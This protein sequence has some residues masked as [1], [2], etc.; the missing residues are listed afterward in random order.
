MPEQGSM[1]SQKSVDANSAYFWRRNEGMLATGRFFDPDELLFTLRF[2]DHRLLNHTGTPGNY[3]VG[4]RGERIPNLPASATPASRGMLTLVP[5]LWPGIP[6]AISA[7][8]RTN[9]CTNPSFGRYTT[10]WNT[11]WAD[12][13]TR[14]LERSYAG[15]YS[16]KITDDAVSNG[17]G[18]WNL[19]TVTIG[20]P[21]SVGCMINVPSGLTYTDVT[22]RV[23]DVAFAGLL[24]TS[25]N[26]TERDQWVYVEVPNVVPTTVNLYVLIFATGG[27]GPFVGESVY[28][29]CVTVVQDTYSHYPPFDGNSGDGYTWTGS[30]E[31]T[32]SSRVYNEIELD[33]M[34][35]LVSGN[36][37]VSYSIWMQAMYDYDTSTPGA[38][39]V[40]LQLIGAGATQQ[41][42]LYDTG[43]NSFYFY[44][45]GTNMTGGTA[46]PFHRGD[47]LHFVATLDYTNDEY[48]IWIN[49]QLVHT[50]T[51]ALTAPTLTTGILG[52]SAGVGAWAY[53][54]FAAFGR[55]LNESEVKA[56]HAHR[57]PLIDKYAID[58]KLN[59]GGIFF[60]AGNWPV[61]TATWTTIPMTS[62]F[63][64]EHM[65]LDRTNN[66]PII[67]EP[68][69]YTLQGS[70]RWATDPVGIRYCGIYVNGVS[71]AL[72]NMDA[73]ATFDVYHTATTTMYLVPG[74]YVELRG[75][76]T[77][78]GNLNAVYQAHVGNF[79]RIVKIRNVFE[80]SY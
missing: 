24:G 13:L 64:N 53:A 18:A 65:V 47:W 45:N 68:G 37:T 34:V 20:L 78:G 31:S 4:T 69:W 17:L 49:G 6:A 23:Y 8:S 11:S 73:N 36:P 5:S 50:W 52:S 77:S 42:M 79:L 80:G 15:P 43:G 35:D 57:T 22:L 56:I 2:D 48:K 41:W 58:K 62:F 75:Y 51:N 1:V 28:V 7:N 10:G 38:Q 40:V 63:I 46:I 12:T 3:F 67:S 54:E 33:S 71:V 25:R 60:Y 26:V 29:D 16:L 14:S 19:T 76:Q 30:A 39:W 32:T 66:R 9:L 44:L 27:A 74:D 21:Y 70:I 61:A 59:V 55:I 72:E